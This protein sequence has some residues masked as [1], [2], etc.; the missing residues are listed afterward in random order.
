MIATIDTVNSTNSHLLESIN[1]I[2]DYCNDI[3]TCLIGKTN[4]VRDNQDQVFYELTS[5]PQK[6]ILQSDLFDC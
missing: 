1:T 2:V 5:K 3:H 6:Q 4:S